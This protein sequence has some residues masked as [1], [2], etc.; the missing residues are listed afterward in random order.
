[1]DGFTVI[2]VNLIAPN[3]FLTQLGSARHQHIQ[4]SVTAGR[5]RFFKSGHT[6]GPKNEKM[7]TMMN[8]RQMG[9]VIKIE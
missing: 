6:N 8:P 2:F 5:F 3:W 9:W 4:L 7:D 1:M